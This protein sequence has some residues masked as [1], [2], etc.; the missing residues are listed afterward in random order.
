MCRFSLTC[1]IF[2]TKNCLNSL[3]LTIAR[4]LVKKSPKFH[5]DLTCTT[6]NTLSWN[7]CFTNFNFTSKCL[8][9]PLVLSSF[10]ILIA[11]W[12]SSWTT[13]YFCTFLK[14]KSRKIGWTH[15]ISFTQEANSKY[16]ACV[17]ERGTTPFCLLD[18]HWTKL[19]PIY[20]ARPPTDFLETEQFAQ[21]A[22]I[23]T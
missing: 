10:K 18:H 7:A 8:V 14:F 17:D 23:N 13:V 11:G 4:G 22:S 3:N 1:P 21:S 9:L 5:I 6:W 15:K 16:S 2:P 12:L 19:G 20:S